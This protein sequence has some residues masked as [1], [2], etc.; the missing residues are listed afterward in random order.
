MPA[1]ERKKNAME[2]QTSSMIRFPHYG[3]RHPQPPLIY[4]ELQNIHNFLNDLWQVSRA[5]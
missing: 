3:P 4:P 1:F 5:A 2:N